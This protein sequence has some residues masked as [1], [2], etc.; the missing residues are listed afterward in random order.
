[1]VDALV[2]L[3]RSFLLVAAAAGPALA[4]LPDCSPRTEPAATLLVPYVAVDLDKPNGH[5]TLVAIGNAAPQATLAR[6]TLWTDMA[7]PTLAFDV[8]LAPD[9]VQTLN[10]RDV[11]NGVLPAGTGGFSF[12]GCSDPLA[13]PALGPAALARL[14]AR[15]TG[16]PD[17]DEGRCHARDHGDRQRVVGFLTADAMNRCPAPSATPLDSGYFVAG[18]S[19]AASNA[20]VLYGDFFL[21]DPAEGFAQAN[22]AAHLVADPERYLSSFYAPLNG[23]SADQRAP[24]GFRH[25]ARY[26]VG[27]GFEAATDLILFGLSDDSEPLNCGPPPTDI[28][29]LGCPPFLRFTMRGES[30]AP[31]SVLTPPLRAITAIYRLGT[32]LLPVPAPFGVVDVEVFSQGFCLGVPQ[33]PYLL[34]SWVLP[35]QS[36]AG[37]YS[38]GLESVRIGDDC[39][40]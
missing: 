37:R 9:A 40:P 35:L 23:D 5:T 22:L 7:V 1:M 28:S 20:N 15:H 29:T 8:A 39:R 38:V 14:R 27:G 12:P 30:G 25:R 11:F 10:L 16:A 31:A 24:L 36:A 4:Q 26:A 21:V 3:A 32:P 18:G 13:R 2:R 33:T 6:I 17:P 34:S 19:G